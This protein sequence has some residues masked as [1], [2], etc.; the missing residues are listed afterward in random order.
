MTRRERGLLNEDFTVDDIV[1]RTHVDIVHTGSTD[2]RPDN[3][4]TFTLFKPVI[5]LI[6]NVF[7]RRL[8]IT[9][10]SFLRFVSHCFSIMIVNYFGCHSDKQL[11][12]N[13]QLLLGPSL[14]T[15]TYVL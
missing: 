12:S 8:Y 4:R 5:L 6:R 14:D 9:R 13:W 1:E 7:S 10:S 11:Q 3:F 15:R 2:V